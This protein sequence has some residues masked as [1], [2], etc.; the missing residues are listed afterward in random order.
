MRH[1]PPTESRS[2]RPFR[3][4]GRDQKAAAYWSDRLAAKIIIVIKFQLVAMLREEKECQKLVFSALNCT[5]SLPYSMSKLKKSVD[6][7]LNI[8]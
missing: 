6:F 4:E 5:Y 7:S 8:A 1:R 3:G 2:R